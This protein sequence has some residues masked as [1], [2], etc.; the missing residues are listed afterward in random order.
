MRSWIDNN[1]SNCYNDDV[2]N[3]Q[4]DN[5]CCS[6]DHSFE[7]EEGV[8][9]EEVVGVGLWRNPF[10]INFKGEGKYVINVGEG[11]IIGNFNTGGS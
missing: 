4:K 10:P 7:V 9:K 11:G 6:L 2:C 3:G 1:G 8:G 5:A